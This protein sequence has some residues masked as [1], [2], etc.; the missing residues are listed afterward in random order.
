MIRILKM[1]LK[2]GFDSIGTIVSLLM[3][4]ACIFYKNYVL[5][6]QDYKMEKWIKESHD[7]S[8]YMFSKCTFYNR[9]IV[10][11]IDPSMLYIFYFLGIIVALPFG[12]SYYNDRKKGLIKNICTRVGKGKYL[13][14]KFVSVFVTGGTV[15]A[16]PIFIDFL[17]SKL[18]YPYDFM[19]LNGTNLSAYSK[20]G[21]FVIDHIYISAFLYI[22]VWFLFGGLLATVSLLVSVIA[23]NVFTV[24]LTP[25]FLMLILFYIPMYFPQ[26]YSKFFPYYFMR[27][28]TADLSQTVIFMFLGIILSFVM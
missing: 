6:S 17:M 1:E 9:W 15:A 13:S 28:G 10:A 21:I 8:Y 2:R 25:F 14:A 5:F 26:K 24:Q 3:G 12:I 23:D 16:V 7:T 18:S 22:L 20:W 4:F 27:Y 11:Y 19:N